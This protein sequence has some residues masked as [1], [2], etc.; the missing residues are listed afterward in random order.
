MKRLSIILFFQLCFVTMIAQ[1]SPFVGT[2][3]GTYKTYKQDVGDITIK[4]FIRINRYEEKY[5]IRI[6]EIP[7][8]SPSEV[9]YWGDCFVTVNNDNSIFFYCKRKREPWIENGKIVS[10]FEATDYYHVTFSEGCLYFG[11][12]KYIVTNYDLRDNFINKKEYPGYRKVTLYK[13]ESDW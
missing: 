3:E 7:V 1:T 9:N 5:R 13:E 12:D 8:N 4:M 10:S 6:K 2:W 11:Y